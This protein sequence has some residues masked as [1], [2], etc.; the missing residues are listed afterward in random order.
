VS[1][2]T[3]EVHI[4]KKKIVGPLYSAWPKMYWPT[5]KE[6][7]GQ[8]TKP[9]GY[10]CPSSNINPPLRYSTVYGVSGSKFAWIFFNSGLIFLLLPQITQGLFVLPNL[11]KNSSQYNCVNLMEDII[12][13]WWKLIGNIIIWPLEN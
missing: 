7:M 12:M 1:F 3:H 2:D 6:S 10:F 8:N 4:V 11:H 9:Q 5:M 13:W